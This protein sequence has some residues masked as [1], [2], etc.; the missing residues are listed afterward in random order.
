[1]VPDTMADPLDDIA[2]LANSANR[3]AVL[4]ALTTGAHH[5]DELRERVDVSRVTL[6]RILDDFEDRRWIERTGQTCRATPLGA[7]VSEAFAE[8]RETMTSEHR[9]REVLP[10]FPAE[11]VSFD[12]RCLRDADI[13][14]P[15]PTNMWAHV[16]RGA[17]CFRSAQRARVVS[18]QTA[19]PI[20][21]ATKTAVEEYEQRFEAVLTAALIETVG[22]NA[23]MAPLFAE[24]LDAPTVDIY[25]YEDE[26]PVTVFLTDGT[27]GLPLTDDEDIARA[28]VLSENE[29][30]YDWAESTFEQYRARSDPVD[31]DAFTA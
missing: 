22:S 14:T 13:V 18:T 26:L 27:V 9:L 6:A 15:T 2:F 23:T 12:V 25:V 20:V 7:W 8:L 10:W 5:R 19:P 29:T 1:M 31:P 16:Q 11:Q 3:V 24:L 17:D 4:E 30:V 28:L 21:E